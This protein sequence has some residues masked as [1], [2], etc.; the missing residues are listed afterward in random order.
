MHKSLKTVHKGP[1][2]FYV[3]A[4]DNNG[5]RDDRQS[6]RTEARIV[7]NLI[8]DAHRLALAFSD[9]SPKEI[10]NHYNALE[11]LLYEKSSG[12]ITG[13][14]R[15]SNRRFLNQ[16]G[17][18]E[19][20]PT[21]TDIWFYIISP[22]T[23]EILSRD[24]EFIQSRFLEQMAQSDI[25]YEASSIARATAEGIYAPI[26]AVDQVHKVKQAVIIKNDVFPYTLIAVA[27]LILI[28]GIIGIIYICISWSRYKNFKQRMRQYTSSTVATATI[29][30]RYDPV[31]IPGPGS[32]H[33]DTPAHLKEYETQVLAMAVNQGDEGDDLQLDFSAKN[34]A[35]NLDNVSYI[36]RKDNGET[37]RIFVQ[38]EDNFSNQIFFFFQ[39]N[40]ST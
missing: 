40:R 28:F 36:T 33:S 27:L 25:N 10:R 26:V 8:T 17:V 3:E 6:L 11:E 22:D 24:S 38:L 37:T 32:Q 31:I 12:Y 29:P 30:K 20:N 19:E 16:D 1:L 9:A 35:F 21:A 5:S 7:V 15:F 34:H 4:V 23:E 18:V 13:I 39:T 14:E 2:A